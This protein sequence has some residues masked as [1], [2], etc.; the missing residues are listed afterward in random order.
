MS[1]CWIGTNGFQQESPLTC[2]S[3]EEFRDP[4]ETT[5]TKYTEIQR[6]KRFSSTP[7]WKRSN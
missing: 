5:Y 2:T 1:R 7:S 6:D 3:W 4:R